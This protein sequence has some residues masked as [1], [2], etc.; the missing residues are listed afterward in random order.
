MTEQTAPTTITLAGHEVGFIK[1]NQGQLEAMIRIM[2]TIERGGDDEQRDFW[3]KQIARVGTLL[4]SLIAEKDRELVDELY[5][6]GQVNSNMLFEAI[7]SQMRVADKPLTL[8]TPVNTA[9]P[10]VRRK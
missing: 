1:P 8:D 9:K 10:R 7:L 6:T 4:E 2:R 5:L 3:Q